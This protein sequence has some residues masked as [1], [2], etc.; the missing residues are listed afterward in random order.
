[1]K[2]HS[3][4]GLQIFTL[5]FSIIVL[6][7]VSM[8][9]HAQSSGGNYLP[10]ATIST[11]LINPIAQIANYIRVDSV[12]IV[13]GTVF[14]NGFPT[15]GKLLTV[16]LTVPFPTNFSIPPSLVH[17]DG[18]VTQSTNGWVPALVQS[19][20]TTVNVKY[21]PT[22]SNPANMEYHFSYIIH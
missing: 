16:Q 20:F 19:D 2:K 9:G 1:M 6:M 4:L 18:V 15:V 10:V 22:S 14:L 5:I 8:K 13:Y 7:L 17:G 12:V 21:T 3:G 11:P